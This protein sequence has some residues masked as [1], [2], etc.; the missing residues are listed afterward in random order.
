MLKI[1]DL[2][3]E[4]MESPIGITIRKPVLSWKSESDINNMLQTAY[5][6]IV[7]DDKA[8]I[9]QGEGSFFDTGKRAADVNHCKLGRPIMKSAR[10]YYWAV[11]IWD[12]HGNESAWSD[13]GEFESGLLY[14]NDWVAKWVEPTQKPTMKDGLG[15]RFPGDPGAGGV[16]HGES[17]LPIDERMFNPC[18]M[19]RKEFDV[20]K[21]VKRARLYATAHGIYSLEL[22]G[23]RVGDMQL[24][25]EITSYRKILQY[26][27][28]DITDLLDEKNAIGAV[29]ADGWWAGRTGGFAYTAQYGD[30]LGL[31]LQI[32]IEYEDGTSETIGTDSSFRSFEGPWRY[33]DL[34]V[35]EK[36]DARYEEE[37]WS[38]PGYK[39]NLWQP[40]HECQYP[41]DNLVGQNAE[42]I[43]VYEILK[44]ARIFTSPRGE[45][46]IDFGQCVSGYARFKLKGKR[47]QEVEFHHTQMLDKDGNFWLEVMGVCNQMRDTYIFKGE[48]EEIYEPRFTYR[49]FQ[50]ICVKG[51]DGEIRPEDVEVKAIASG[52][53]TIGDF[54]C[55]DEKVNKLQSCVKYT[56]L[57]NYLAIPT[58]DCDRERAGWTGDAGMVAPAGNFI[59]NLLPFWKRWLASFRAEQYEDGRIDCIVPMHESLCMMNAWSNEWEDACI[60]LPW[61]A[62]KVSGDKDILADNYEMMQKW[63]DYC[64][65]SAKER[66]PADIGELTPERKK[67]LEYIRNADFQWGDWLTPSGNYDEN[68]NYMYFATPLAEYTPCF[69]MTYC[70][71]LLAK[72]ADVLDKPDDAAFYQL[73]AERLRKATIAE[74]FDTGY[75]LNNRFQGATILALKGGFYPEEKHDELVNRLLALIEKHNGMDVGFASAPFISEV[76]TSAGR[77]DAAY[78]L[79]FNENPGGWLYEINQGATT[80]WEDWVAKTPDGDLRPVSYSLPA[81][82]GGIAAWLYKMVAGINSLEAGYKR[83]RIAP[84]LDPRG[85]LTY[86][87]AKTDTPYGVLSSRW[88]IADGKMTL[89]VDIP[90]NTQAEIVLPGI[91]D[92]T[93]VSV[94]GSALDD[95][96]VESGAV[97]V[98]S[99][100][101]KFEYAVN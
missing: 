95:A 10:R 80:L 45:T 38:A 14:A 73:H 93:G 89:S 5:R 72:I 97:V 16:D 101:Y 7:S 37:G 100:K 8:E 79:L 51:Y 34:T 33:A 49:G 20:G 11:K 76:L 22:N 96:L 83:S 81:Y 27:T 64:I 47:G 13:I 86:A 58:D 63:M 52:F 43:K 41:L 46:I 1:Y 17:K 53:A 30:M 39:D 55:S 61:E 88:E 29:V 50:Y 75:I 36:Y 23:Q 59:F 66:N 69:Y 26:Q 82:G 4:Q 40:V 94:N 25:P 54:K 87:E 44:P 78:D 32:N 57:S 12:N 62:Y 70:L 92:L 84:V 98:G 71:E 24:A 19:L 91:E 18:Q 85:R 74:Y 99:G 35:G 3:C 15:I 60:I 77:A 67:N 28:Y 56:I 65:T 2:K 21:K 6:V 31:L 68:G 90:A 48:D 42:P 9:L